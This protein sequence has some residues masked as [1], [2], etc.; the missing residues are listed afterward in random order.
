MHVHFKK[1]YY[2]YIL[3]TFMYVVC[4]FLYLYV[5]TY[6]LTGHSIRHTLL[7]PGW[8]PFVFRTALILRGIDSA[9]FVN[10][11]QRCWFI[12]S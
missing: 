1:I 3:N 8:T 4:L 9:G 5:Y 7:V 10:I 12:L 11:P 2:V 6:T